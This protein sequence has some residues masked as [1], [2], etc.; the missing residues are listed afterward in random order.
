MENTEDA[1]AHF[2]FFLNIEIIKL[3]EN[4][5]SHLKRIILF[6]QFL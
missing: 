3:I 4:K 1:P 2:L 6:Y 5:E